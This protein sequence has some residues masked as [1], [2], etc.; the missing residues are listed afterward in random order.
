MEGCLSS[1]FDFKKFNRVQSKCFSLIY[2]TNHNAVISAPTGSGK[3]VLFEL[4]I[5]RLY[6][7]LAPEPNP[8]EAPLAIYVAPMKALC[9]E[10]SKEWKPRYKRLG[11]KVVEFT[12]DTEAKMMSK[13]AKASVLLTTPEKWDAFTRRWREHKKL[14]Q[15][16]RLLL[17][18]EVHLLST[19]RGGMLEAIVSRMQSIANITGQ[20]IRIIAQSATIPNIQDL[21]EWLNVDQNTGL[22]NFGEE[23][24]PI[25][26]QKHVLGYPAARNEFL[27]E[28][29]LDF[30]LAEVIRKYSNDRAALVFCQ[31]Q[32]GTATAASR[33]KGDLEP[34]L[35]NPEQQVELNKAAEL[36]KDKGLQSSFAWELP[37][38]LVKAG[39]AF[40]HGG[41]PTED[42][43]IIED[44]FREGRGKDIIEE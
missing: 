34:Q 1:F 38:G 7:D 39:I 32:R 26:L 41:L 35:D 42:R 11:L 4:S 33:L 12:G 31:T 28:R 16:I 6:K 19:D 44:L 17:I 40:H 13:V 8:K 22:K 5:L 37:V 30:K 25:K 3:S 2:Q 14:V 43:R 10:K 20:E 18:D 36:L 21:C 27:F 29:A 15:R 23:Y 9:Q 24:R